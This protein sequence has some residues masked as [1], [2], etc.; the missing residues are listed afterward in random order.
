ML[1]RL[2][3]TLSMLML[4]V[5]VGVFVWAISDSYQH[6][7]LNDIFHVKLKERFDEEVADQRI[8]FDRYVKAY[9]PA[10]RTYAQLTGIRDY[11]EDADW[12]SEKY[13]EIVDHKWSPKW[14]PKVSMMR[15]F[16]I[17]RYALLMDEDNKVKE[18][19][20]YKNPMLPSSL[21]N[22]SEDLLD[23]SLGQSYLAEV[24]DQL[25][26]VASAFVG[27]E[28]ESPRLL[29]LSPVDEE[30]LLESQGVASNKNI[31][32][33]NEA[34]DR[35]LV[36]S[37]H[38]NIP[39][40]ALLKDL[41]QN[42]LTTVAGHLGSGEADL[43]VKFASFVSTADV[44]QQ[45]EAV[46]NADRQI[47]SLTALAYVLAF[48]GVMYWVTSRIQRLTK[49]VV[50]F[51]GAM[52]I[53]QP[54]YKR[55]DELLELE[56][57]FE[58]LVKAVKAETEALE[59]Q[60]LHDTLTQMPNRKL[61]N[62][63][64]RLELLKS[65]FKKQPF[66][67]MV[68]DLD[69]FKEIN[70][71][72][73]HHIGDEVLQQASERLQKT[74]RKDDTV[75]RLGG[76][77]F[78]MLL[79]NTNLTTCDIVANKI[80][81]AFSHPI[82]VEEQSLSVG[83]S[84]GIVEYPTHGEDLNLLMQRADVAMYNAKQNKLGYSIYKQE[85]DENTIGRLALMAEFREAL[86]KDELQLHYQPKF[87][88]ASRKI[89]SAEALL[90][91]NHPVNGFIPP[92][93]FIPLAEQTGLVL[94]LTLWVF[95]QA[96]EDWKVW[97]SEGN[98]ISVAINLSVYC[99][100]F[101][102]LPGTIQTILS[103]HQV[104]AEYVILELT[105]N[106]F[107]KDAERAKKILNELDAFGLELS[108]DDFGTGYSSLSYLKQLPMDEIKIDRSFVVDMVND[109]NDEAIVK[110]TIEMAHAMKLRV[111]AEGVEDEDTLNRLLELGCDIS[112][113]YYFAKPMPA[114]EFIR[115]LAAEKKAP[116]ALRALPFIAE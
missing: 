4:T 59:H 63:R 82:I 55:Q 11:V 113:G 16:V 86:S 67:L 85:E 24:D 10:V 109:E 94:P 69:R 90:R 100:Q 57:R 44:R 65:G 54:I 61:L 87:D 68:S 107:M 111:V 102:N 80:V 84:V 77:E 41:K 66:L 43:L 81:D 72:L 6:H 27:D 30:F 19:Y 48:A 46:L 58:L 50:E 37:D 15:R 88:L 110:A 17:P 31:A 3:L 79:P 75:A 71:T 101:T 106:L 14:L 52:E 105:E 34:G 42:H 22:I 51:S 95:N 7:E 73:G 45:T 96:L 25:Y 115:L 2:P 76:D 93:E 20:R 49:K 36:S 26:I 92:D 116:R 104:P 108:I 21:L 112:Q 39:P 62:D 98:D 60:A 103:K 23:N 53:E 13:N 97:H 1:K 9:H 114:V 35:V 40:G 38:E 91:W 78:G 74:L 56:A 83:I 64:I 47:R 33:L 5:T 8:R 12:D 28:D 99:L 29:I 89:V 32:L 70:D 18:I